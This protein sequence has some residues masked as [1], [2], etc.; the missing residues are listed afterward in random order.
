MGSENGSGFF[1]GFL[2]G[3]LGSIASSG[4]TAVVGKE[5]ASTLGGMIAF[6][7]LSGGIGAELSGG[8][9]FK[10]FMQGGMV[11]GLNHSLHEI[12]GSGDDPVKRRREI[13]K[14]AKSHNG[15]TDWAYDKE[16]GRFDAGTNKCNQFVDDVLG[17]S[18]IY[19]PDPNGKLA[20]VGFGTPVTAGQWA[21]PNYNIPGW[22]VVGS[23]QAGDIVAISANFSNATGHVGIMISS[24]ESIYAAHNLVKISD[25]GSSSRH[26]VN[27]PGNNGYV[28][29]R[30]IGLPS[31]NMSGV[32][33][34]GQ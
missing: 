28:Y 6:G 20:I 7:A 18:G 33:L 19:T 11:A 15:S 12:A 25:F 1:Q 31:V 22:Q 14:N 9:F 10:G 17:E 2:S 30:Y 3:A 4:W 27:Y 34:F 13:V 24:T 21:D 5:T 29:R 23:P 16:N 32:K 26:F 8:N